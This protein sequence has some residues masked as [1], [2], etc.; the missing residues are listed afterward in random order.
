MRLP[1]PGPSAKLAA[2]SPRKN[3]AESRLLLGDFL[4][5]EPPE[6]AVEPDQRAGKRGRCRWFGVDV[7]GVSILAACAETVVIMIVG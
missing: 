4:L 1:R 7:G 3:A 6:S 2:V 5:R